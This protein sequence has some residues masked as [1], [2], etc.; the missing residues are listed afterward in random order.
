M[1]VICHSVAAAKNCIDTLHFYSFRYDEILATKIFH[2]FSNPM[3]I[4]VSQQE[5]V[6]WMCV[7]RLPLQCTQRSSLFWDVTLRRLVVICL[8]FGTT[9]RSNPLPFFYFLFSLYL[10]FSFCFFLYVPPSC[11]GQWP[12]SL[13]APLRPGLMNL[14]YAQRFPLHK[15]SLGMQHS[16]LSQFFLVSLAWPA[17]LCCD[18]CMDVHISDCLEIV[19]ELLLLPHNTEWN[20]FTQIASSVKCCLDVCYWGAVGGDWACTWLWTKCFT[21]LFLNKKY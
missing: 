13:R 19:F 7:F 18:E 3:F 15:D 17:S 10:Y 8:H 14:C 1:Y 6:L 9:C 4:P 21:V 16:L 11:N 5:V 20:I 12:L 2:F